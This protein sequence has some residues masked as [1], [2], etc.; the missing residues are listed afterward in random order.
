MDSGSFVYLILWFFLKKDLELLKTGLL[1][2]V[3]I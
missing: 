3:E 1:N 2:T